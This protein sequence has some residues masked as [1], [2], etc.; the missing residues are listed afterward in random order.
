[1]VRVVRRLVLD[2][3]LATH[4][5]EVTRGAL[6]VVEEALRDLEFSVRASRE[7]GRLRGRAEA[8]VLEKFAS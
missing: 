4:L 3:E 1:M 8:V 6:V 2:L 5:R 7:G